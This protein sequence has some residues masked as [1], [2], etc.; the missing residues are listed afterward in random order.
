MDLLPF[1]RR[2]LTAALAPG[3]DISGLS[4]PRG[5]GK[6]T[7]VAHLSMRFL[8]PG[9]PLHVA[10]A[11]SHIVAA[12]I[13]QARRTVFKQLRGM[14]GDDP[15]YRVAESVNNVHVTHK[16]T[17]TRIS[18]LAAN[19]KTAQGLVDVPFV[20][21]D[22]PGSWELSGGQMVWDAI[23]TALGKP[24]SDMRILLIGTLAPLGLPGHWWANLVGDG[25]CAGVHVTAHMG[26]PERWD[27]LR[28]VHSVN[29]LMSRFP[30]SRR[31]LL[32]E[33]NAA[34]GDTR[35]KAR[36]LSYRLNVPTADESE[37][38]LTVDD[39]QAVCR[40]PEALPAGR[41]IVGIDLGAGRAWSAAVAIWKSG[42]V[43]ALAVAPGIPDLAAQEKR[44]RVPAGTYQRLHDAGSLRVAT[45]LHVQPPKQLAGLIADTWG[46]PDKV[47]CDRFRLD[48]LRDCRTG[49]NL[50][51]RV[52]RW[53]EAS[54][55]IRALRKMAKD[56]PLSSPRSSRS[57]LKASLA[58][59][60]VQPDDAGN[61]R[62]VKRG[63]NNQARDDVAAALTLAAGE[64]AR[65]DAKPARKRGAYVGLVQ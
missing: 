5:N 23:E 34:R 42:R 26:N 29:P 50:A 13:G 8:T 6:S 30:K 44:D 19:G 16:A 24:D 53:S 31:T 61:C 15:D 28:H 38:L 41:P 18:V 22:E 62:L 47:L 27:D 51:P 40:R 32:K 37:V 39:W 65:Q 10:G 36:F 45:G 12:S 14:I 33:R 9:D 48:D 2:F 3:I 21:A 54:E 1:Q 60:L 17:G 7:L 25:S 52:T 43:E 58:V 11:E 56:G 20:F 4:L 57:I 63:T 55:D 35:L 59:A 46:R 49:W 64:W